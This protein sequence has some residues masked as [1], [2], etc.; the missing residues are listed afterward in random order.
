MKPKNIDSLRALVNR[1]ETITLDE[2]EAAFKIYPKEKVANKL[3][4]FGTSATCSL[5][6]TVSRNDFLTPNCSR[7]VYNHLDVPKYFMC[8]K[9]KNTDTYENIEQAR[10]P[11]VLL[12]AFRLRA[13]H[14]R[15]TYPQFFG[16]N[17]V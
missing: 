16:S 7:C 3:T 11:T 10:F 5:C 4:G 17:K 15:Q 1:Y 2:I 12:A 13:Q 9:G 14:I 8:L 6:I